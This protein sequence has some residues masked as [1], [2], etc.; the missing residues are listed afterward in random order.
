MCSDIAAFSEKSY[1]ARAAA[2]RGSK[3]G[4]LR[5]RERVAPYT[6][7]PAQIMD[8]APSA[9]RA[10]PSARR[11]AR[12]RTAARYATRP[13]D[14]GH[15]VVIARRTGATGVQAARRRL[16]EMALADFGQPEGMPG[17]RAP[18]ACWLR[19]G[20]PTKWPPA[21]VA[22]CGRPPPAAHP[23]PRAGGRGEGPRAA[24]AGAAAGIG[25][26][27]R[28]EDRTHRRPASRPSRMRAPSARR[29]SPPAR[30]RSRR[31]TTGGR[32]RDGRPGE[33]AAR[34]ALCHQ[35]AHPEVSFGATAPRA[36]RSRVG[37]PAKTTCHPTARPN[38]NGKTV[39][40]RL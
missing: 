22:G 20:P 25:R 14:F 7:R 34:S 16:G 27:K 30:G 3:Q 11:R 15:P 28:V 32:R 9:R 40:S 21:D 1:W 10:S 26:V 2:R 18:R 39:K 23:H 5:I 13:A 6:H 38:C 12:R 29:A 8:A 33:R 37:I 17:A 31:R 36:H 24:G 35:T 4:A 19:V